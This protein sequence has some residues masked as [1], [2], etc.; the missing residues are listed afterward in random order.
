MKENFILHAYK[1]PHRK[2]VKKPP[3]MAKPGA[4]IS[5]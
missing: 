3:K 1:E 5:F 2:Q 4:Y